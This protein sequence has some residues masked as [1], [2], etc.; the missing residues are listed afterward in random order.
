M[1]VHQVTPFR[2]I[3]LLLLLAIGLTNSV[4]LKAEPDGKPP[5][6]ASR[7]AQARVSGKCVDCQKDC[8]SCHS[9]K[10][11]DLIKPSSHDRIWLETHAAAARWS[12]ESAHGKECLL[13]H[14]NAGCVSCHRTSPPRSHNGLWNVRMHGTAAKWDRESCK[15]CH[16]TGACISCHRRTP[17]LNHRGNW[18]SNHGRITGFDDS[19][20][21]CHHAGWC[22][23]CHKGSR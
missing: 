13:C 15:T 2:V 8:T 5:A 7:K 22:I 12:S 6:N 4:T 23:N 19:C 20:V 10:R 11:M 21:T 9:G 3:I 1:S 14:K 16:E 17:P 18:V